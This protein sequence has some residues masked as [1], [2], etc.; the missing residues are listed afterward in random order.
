MPWRRN[1]AHGL[2]ERN[3]GALAQRRGAQARRL[4]DRGARPLRDAARR[5][6]GGAAPDR[7]GAVV[8]LR[9]GAPSVRARAAR[10]G[11]RGR[12]RHR[13]TAPARRPPRAGARLDRRR[14]RCTSPSPMASDGYFRSAK[15]ALRKLHRAGI[16][17][18]D[19]AKEQNWLR[20][21]DG[22]AYLTDFQLAALFRRRDAAVPH[23]GLRGSAPPAQAQAPLRAGCAH[24]RRAARAGAARACRPASGWRPARRSII[25]ITRDVLRFT[26]REGG[27]PRLV[28]DAPR[29][30]ARLKAHPQVRDVAIVAFPD[31]R[32]GTGL[33]AF[34]EGAPG[35]TEHSLREF[36]AAEA[37]S[38][39]APKPPEHLQVIEELPRN[40]SGEVRSEILQ[41]V[42]MNQVDLIDAADRKR[43]GT[44]RW[45]PA[46]SPTAATCATASRSRAH[47]GWVESGCAL[48]SSI[49]AC[50]SETG[51]HFAGTCAS[52]I[53]APA[54]GRRARSAI[55]AAMAR[56][57]PARTDRSRAAPCARAS[58]P[59]ARPAATRAGPPAMRMRSC[60]APRQDGGGRGDAIRPGPRATPVTP[61]RR[62]T[63]CR[64]VP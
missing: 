63:A 56:S 27:G 52:E 43:A 28:Y 32:A 19:L 36:M 7:R 12:A 64:S 40:A 42:A 5:G 18:N 10:A 26:D 38:E 11:A 23:R 2:A 45:S 24:R 60:F 22:R 21:T 41:L 46:S 20:G 59:Q 44:Q 8:E 51:L 25:W 54:A 35:L 31:R 55:A 61:A 9:L 33:Y 53:S 15:A 3:R 30:A 62:A 47:P 16:S 6:R 13:A 29:I 50:P 34:V 14:R 49:G 1:D 48:D 4:L 58:A 39:Q 37:A 57:R 17:H